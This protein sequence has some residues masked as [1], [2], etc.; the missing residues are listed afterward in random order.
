MHQVKQSQRAASTYVAI[1]EPM[2]DYA[3]GSK[4]RQELDAAINKYSNNVEDIPI[5]IGGEEIRTKDIRYQ[6]EVII[7]HQTNLYKYVHF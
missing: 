2:Y 4:E 6:V 5:V 1:N 3:A 7:Y